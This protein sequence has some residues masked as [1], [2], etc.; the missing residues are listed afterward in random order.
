MSK[1]PVPPVERWTA[2]CCAL[3]KRVGR[4]FTIYVPFVDPTEARYGRMLKL[5]QTTANQCVGALLT[6]RG[7]GRLLNFFWPL[8]GE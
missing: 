7:A 8:C 1:V 2:S 4:S 3:E 5:K 6:G